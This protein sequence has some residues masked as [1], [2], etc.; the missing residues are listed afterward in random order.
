MVYLIIPKILIM[1]ALK[2]I[3][4]LLLIA[5]I[6]FCIYVAVQPNEFSFNRSK[7]IKAPA[8]MLYNKVNDYKNWPSFSPWIEQEPTAHLSYA[9]K[10]VGVGG[11]YSWNGEILGEG[12]METLNVDENKL[13]EQR[14]QFIKPFESESDIKW[15]FEPTD[16][17]TK[18]TWAMAGKQDFMTKMVTTFKGSIE[19]M[20]APDFERGLF[21]LDSIVTADME[22]YTITING[23]TQ[24]SG[25]FY[26]YSTTSCKISDIEANMEKTMP[27]ITQYAANNNIQMAGPPFTYIHKW[28]EANNAVI[29]SCCVPTISKVV[30]TQDDVLTGQLLPFKALKT[31]LKGNYSNL[32]EAWETSMQHINNSSAMEFEENGPMLEVYLNNPKTTPNPANWMTEIYIAIK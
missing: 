10:T 29:F 27:K 3:L 11:G 8:S 20:T 30:T 16:N 6:G 24:H 31:T 5:V 32:K 21:K 1:K 15:T 12:H 18:V 28:D 4:F 17:G 23:E 19:E 2:Y 25:G 22:K 14:I 13:I 7:L 26:I 9:D